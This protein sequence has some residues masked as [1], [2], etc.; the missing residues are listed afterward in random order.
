MDRSQSNDITTLVDKN[1]DI[2]TI[3]F[4]KLGFNVKTCISSYYTRADMSG[5]AA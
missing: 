1:N 3:I 4:L 2:Y 5:Q